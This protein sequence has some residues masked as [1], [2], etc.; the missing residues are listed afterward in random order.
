MRTIVALSLVLGLVAGWSGDVEARYGTIAGSWF[1]DVTPQAVPPDF[2]E[3]PPP[4]VSI[5]N[6][7][8]ARTVTETDSALSPNSIV[9]LFP[10]DVFPP[11]SASDG[12]GAWKRTGHHRFKCTFLKILFDEEG[13]QIGFVRNTLSLVLRRNGT[14]EGKGISHFVMGSDPDGEVFFSGP[15]TLEGSPLTVHD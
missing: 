9:A 15:V 6:F 7:E 13:A 11:F 4:F 14:L 5:L 10:A 8:L 12:Y 1:I 3:P 2:P